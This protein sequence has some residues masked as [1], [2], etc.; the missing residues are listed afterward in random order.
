MWDKLSVHLPYAIKE[1]VN[2]VINFGFDTS[3]FSGRAEPIACFA[4]LSQIPRNPTC[5]PSPNDDLIFLQVSTK[6]MC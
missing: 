4:T 3:G 6:I 2:I 5:A 1:N